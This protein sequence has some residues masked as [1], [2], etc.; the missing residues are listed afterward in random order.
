MSPAAFRAPGPQQAKRPSSGK[1][2][3]RNNCV[4]SGRRPRRRRHQGGQKGAKKG[5]KGGRRDFVAP[6]RGSVGGV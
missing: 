4:S 3:Q 1:A 2:V 6:P 5:P